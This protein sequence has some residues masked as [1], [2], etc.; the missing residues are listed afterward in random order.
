MV[1]WLNKPENSIYSLC[2]LLSTYY[3]SA[4][5]VFRVWVIS[6]RMYAPVAKSTVCKAWRNLVLIDWWALSSQS[7][8]FSLHKDKLYSSPRFFWHLLEIFQASKKVL[9]FADCEIGWDISQ[10]AKKPRIVRVK[11]RKRKKP[12]TIEKAGPRIVPNCK[13]WTKLKLFF[14]RKTEI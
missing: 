2:Q 5:L 1:D 12:I 10:S 4:N 3:V 13:R 9:I 11:K 14:G 7:E 8:T 6:C